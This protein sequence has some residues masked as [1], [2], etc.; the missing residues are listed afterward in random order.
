MKI[1]KFIICLFVCIVPAAVLAQADELPTILITEVYYN[2][3][4]DDAISEWIEIANISSEAIDISQYNIGDAQT[5][6]AYEGMVRFPEQSIVEAGQVIVV[7]Q[8]AVSFY[9][10][11]GFNPDYEI[12]DTDPTVPDMRDYPLWS[13]GSLGLA[14]DGDEVLL[15]HKLTI[16]DTLNYGDSTFFFTPAINGVLRGQSIERVPANCDTDTAAGWLPREIP[17]PGII[18]LEGDC[19]VPRNPAD[20]NPLQP[21][22]EIQGDGSYSP[23][24]NQIVEFRGIVTGIQADQN[25]A[26]TTYY[27]VFVQDMPGLEDGDLATSDAMPLFL[28]WERPFL[29]IGD[30]VQVKGLVTEFFGLTEI[31]SDGLE[32]SVEASE[33]PLP[34]PI[35]IDPPEDSDEYFEALEGMLVAMPEARVIGPTHVA[36]GFAVIAPDGPER[37]I[38]HSEADAIGQIVPIL[39][40]TDVVCDDFPQVKTGDTVTGLSGPL[41]YHFDQFKIVQQGNDDLAVTAVPFPPLPAAQA[42]NLLT[43][44]T[45]NLENHF[46]GLDDT[47]DEAEPKPSPADISLRQTKLAYAIGQ[48]LACPTLIGIQE[49][50]KKSLL[51]ALAAELAEPCGFRYTV[52]HLES[53]D[54]RGIDVALLSDPTR[55]QV[56]SASLQ[57]G[58]TLVDTGIRDETAV[59]PSNQSPLFSRPPLQAHLTINGSELTI[60]VNHF[61]SKRGGDIETAPRRRA[62]A[63]H[64]ADMVDAQLE[65]NPD[66]HIIVLGDFNDYENSPPLQ[67]MTENGRLTNTLQQIPEQERYSYN[68]SGASQLIDGIL[69]SPSL[70]EQIADVSILHVN[71]DYPDSL[72]HDISPA[73]LPYKATDHD[74]SLLTLNPPP[75]PNQPTPTNQP[76]LQPAITP[77]SQAANSS[78]TPTIPTPLLIAAAILGGTAVIGALAVARRRQSE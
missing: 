62:Q 35:F 60:Y 6:G 74:L 50:E 13:S 28:G 52:T 67:L 54:V 65:T 9:Q 64:I 7:A 63:Q 70:A 11:F 8:T 46:D 19:P 5:S 75:P 43:I 58:C 77:L 40:H 34:Q 32:I 45:L 68:F 1:I 25:T 69:V 27:T 76:T 38:R 47:G 61:K 78:A 14:N 22:G 23:Y 37:L 33:Q 59:C 20:T 31:D 48:T 10:N 66:A 26:G 15:L 18:T 41:T 3:P 24:V 4:G 44:A 73:N 17:T 55:V 71:A 53:A 12:T 2:T 51:D 21:I 16:L 49:V 56:Q 72:S 39:N 42:T 29:K 57:Q 36:C 30:Q